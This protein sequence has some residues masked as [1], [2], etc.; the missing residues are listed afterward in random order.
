VCASCITPRQRSWPLA[1]SRLHFG[2]VGDGADAEAFC[3]GSA[4]THMG[5]E[6]RVGSW[7][8]AH[9]GRGEGGPR[10]RSRKPG[11]SWNG[12][13][14]TGVERRHGWL[15]GKSS[16]G[17]HQTLRAD[18]ARNKATR[19][20]RAE[21]AERVRN[22]ESGRCQG[23]KLAQR[24]PGLKRRKGPDPMGGVV[25]IPTLRVLHHRTTSVIRRW[26]APFG[27]TA[28]EPNRFGVLTYNPAPR[29]L[30]RGRSQLRP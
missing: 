4:G 7:G 27:R 13:R 21:T 12:K 18:V 22:P 26:E 3:R 20:R 30:S 23:G 14:A 24:S 15:S 28:R 2:G 25:E 9:P 1:R 11:A 6:R 17:H 16:G 19:S 10:A 8:R 5:C 29:E